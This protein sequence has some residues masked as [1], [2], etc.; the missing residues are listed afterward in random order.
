MVR[1][2]ENPAQDSE[3]VKATASEVHTGVIGVHVENIQRC[4]ILLPI[5]ARNGSCDLR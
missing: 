4:R 5:V 3:Y 2:M 1:Y